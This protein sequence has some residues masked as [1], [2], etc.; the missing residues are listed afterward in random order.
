MTRHQRLEAAPHWQVHEEAYHKRNCWSTEKAVMCMHEGGRTSLWTSAKIKPAF[1]QSHQQST[2]DNTLW[3]VSFPSQ[4]SISFWTVCWCCLPKIIKISRC[5]T[6]LL[7]HAKVGSFLRHS[8]ELM[9]S[10]SVQ[11][12]SVQ[13][14]TLLK[15]NVLRG[16]VRVTVT[17]GE[18]LG[19]AEDV[20]S[21]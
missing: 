17:C 11:F 16:W 19:D 6:K 13:F 4:L 2:G 7:E 21:T 1:F 10:D 18:I 12:S 8:S 14:V 9:I 5:L 15:Q 20:V 3:F